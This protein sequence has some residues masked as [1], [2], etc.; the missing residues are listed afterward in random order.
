MLRI[1]V[2]E[3]KITENVRRESRGN[4]LWYEL[5]RGLSLRGFELSGVNCMLNR[6]SDL[7][8]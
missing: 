6:N 3:G 1:R 4:R 8:D 7:L 2:T 5:T